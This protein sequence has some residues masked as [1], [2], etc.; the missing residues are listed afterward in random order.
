MSRCTSKQPIQSST[1][2]QE[3]SEDAIY[4][5]SMREPMDSG[6][7]LRQDLQVDNSTSGEQETTRIT[8]R[9]TIVGAATQ[10]DRPDTR[11]SKRRKTEN[12]TASETIE[13]HLTTESKEGKRVRRSGRVGTIRWNEEERPSPDGLVTSLQHGQVAEADFVPPKVTSKSMSESKL[14][15]T[16]TTT[17]TTATNQKH[18]E[19][20]RWVKLSHLGHVR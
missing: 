6:T 16:T 18:P 10:Y 17:T 2:I 9:R 7:V 8:R 5:G 1:G 13:I 11:A 4:N 19:S 12:T 14:A 20:H 15:T 3:I